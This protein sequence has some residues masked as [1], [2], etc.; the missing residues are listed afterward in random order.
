MCDDGVVERIEEARRAVTSHDVARQAGVSRSTVS[1][2]LNGKGE[3]YPD[4][5]HQRVL[6]AATALDY[7]PSLAGRSLKSGRSDTIVVLL[8]NTTFGSNLQDAVDQ[9]VESTGPRAG[10][11]VVRFASETPKAT[12]DA[13][14]ALRPLALVDLGVLSPEDRDYLEDRGTIITPRRPLTSTLDGG[15]AELQADALLAKGPKPLWF[16]AIA[17]QRDDL[18]GPYRLAGLREY[19]AQHGIP[20]PRQVNVPIDAPGGAAAIRQILAEGAPV[21]VACYNDDVAL[22]LL[23]GARDLGLRVPEEIAIIGVDNTRVGQLWSPQL[24]SVDTSFRELISGIAS[25][26]RAR[27][28]GQIAPPIPTPKF[29]LVT[30][31]TH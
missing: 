12:R 20:E 30:G 5:T 6:A 13:V 10:N 4:A 27:L 2:I 8:P 22:A 17:D 3:R 18:Y 28:D 9:V 19:C 26:L 25:D 1:N 7:R 16:A 31:G 29:K 14:L 23:A 21:G 15:I 24:S 11:V